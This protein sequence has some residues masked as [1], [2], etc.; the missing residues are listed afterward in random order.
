MATWSV[1]IEVGKCQCDVVYSNTITVGH[2][3]IAAKLLGKPHIWHLHEFGKEDHGFGFY[4]G[5]RFSCK[6]IGALSSLCIVVS[7]ALATKHQQFIKPSKVRVVYPSMHLRLEQLPSADGAEVPMAKRPGQFRCIIVGGVVVGKRQ[8][9]AIQAF[10]L[11]EKENFHAELAIVGGSENLQYRSDLDRIVREHHL[12]NKVIFM[13]EVRDARPL[14]QAAGV[15]LVC[16]RSEGFGRVTI[17]A[18][19]AGKPVIGASAGATPELVQEGFNGLVY[20]V[21]NPSALAEKIRYLYQH[22]DI[23]S[24]LGENGKQWAQSFF[25][26]ERYSREIAGVLATLLTPAVSQVSSTVS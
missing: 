8:E 13:G 19:L 11:L 23:A 12:E 9:D 4:F 15:L 17:E 24:R 21:E 1:M 14:I 7:K 10:A 22:P 18:M 3:A 25:T 6:T 2:G 26:K 5:E 20:E 16:S